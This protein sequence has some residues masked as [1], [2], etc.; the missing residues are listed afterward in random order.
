M[1]TEPDERLIVALDTP[2]LVEA[3]K[4][5]KALQ[6]RVGFYKIGFELFIAHG[7]Q[8]VD[9][10]RRYGGRVFLDLK[11]HDIPNTVAKAVSAV[12]EHG[13][14]ILNVHALGGFDMMFKAREIAEA[15]SRRVRTKRPL[16]LGVT[17]LTSHNQ[18]TLSRELGIAK[19][20]EAEVLD[21]ARLVKKAGLDGVVCSPHEAA[22]IRSEFSSSFLIVTPGVRPQGSAQDDQ[23]RIFTPK[24]ALAAGANYLVIGRPVTA[25]P[26]PVAAAESI[27][28]EIRG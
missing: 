13:V 25:A 6:G 16:L 4:L 21:L 12:A 19:N 9:L 17:I 26:D 28:A 1:K 15:A 7:W 27:L 24:Q 11:L 22:M 2:C 8:A 23:K 3:E 20:L 5:L 14:D 18:E 10:V